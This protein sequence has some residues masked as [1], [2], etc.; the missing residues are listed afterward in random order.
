[1]LAD[2]LRLPSWWLGRPPTADL[3]PRLQQALR[4]LLSGD[5]EKQVARRLGV[6][7]HTAHAYVKEIYRRVGVAS[8][9]ELLGRFL[10]TLPE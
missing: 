6:T 3:P 9:A 7:P 4:A 2:V 8:R 1:M 10:P 5:S